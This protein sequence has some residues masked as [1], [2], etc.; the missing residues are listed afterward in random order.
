MF[1]GIIEGKGE[2]LSFTTSK[3]AAGLKIWVPKVF[4]N[5]KIGASL[6]VNGVCLTV[7]KKSKNELS[8]DVIGETLKKS[9]FKKLKVGQKVNLERPI[10]ASGRLDGHL[11][12]GHVDG[13]GKIVSI[14]EQ[15]YEISFPK[16][17]KKF[18]APKGSI[19]IDGTSLTI[20]KRSS[21]TF[22]VHLIPHTLKQT[23]FSEY[24]VGTLVNLETDILLKK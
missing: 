5:A 21:S 11:V 16:R 13:V 15:S 10:K 12:L 2:V 23:I 9:T 17:F 1:T 8:F 7:I 6:A 19:A 3:K 18:I 24:Q 20:G 4:C 22:W 14:K